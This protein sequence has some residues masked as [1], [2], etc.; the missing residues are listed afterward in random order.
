MPRSAGGAYTVPSGTEA[1][2]GATISSSDYNN[3]L[4]DLESEVSDSLSR[5]GKGALTADMSAG[6]FKITNLAAGTNANDAVRLV[7]LTAGY[8]PLDAD[9]TA[10]AALA[11]TAGMVSRTGA[12]TFAVRTL[13]VSGTGLSI[14]DPTGAAGAPTIT[15]NPTTVVAA[16]FVAAAQ[17][18]QETATSTILPVTPGRQHFHPSAAKCWAYVTVSAGSPTLQ[19]SYNITSIT[20]TATGQLTVTIATDF[21]SANWSPQMAVQY[22]STTI[23]ADNMRIGHIRSGSQAAGTIILECW[24]NG[25]VTAAAD[26]S[27]WSFEGYGDQA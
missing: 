21:S 15:L 4:D 2:S 1:V 10:L 8:Q 7:Q 5:S 11:A 12:G 26:P 25:G 19:T 16:G 18:D 24:D 9:L 14:A 17:S 20:D 13:A 6:T 22:A 23:N 3:L 27:A